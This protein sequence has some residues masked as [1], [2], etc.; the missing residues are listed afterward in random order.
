MTKEQK[1]T[2]LVTA[3][4]IIMIVVA[5]L[6]DQTTAKPLY[7]WLTIVNVP[8]LF[9]VA[10]YWATGLRWREVLLKGIKHYVVP[11]AV[12]A[13]ITI[14]GSK[15]IIKFNWTYWMQYRFVA[16]RDGV[17]TFLY[18]NGWPTAHV[19]DWQ[20]LGTGM[21]WIALALFVATIVFKVVQYLPG[22][23]A[24]QWVVTI[25]LAWLGYYLSSQFQMPWSIE[26]ALVM[27]PLMMLGK[28]L[29]VAGDWQVGHATA[30]AGFL[31][32]TG[33]STSGPF[34]VI[35][36]AAPHWVFT[37][38]GAVLGSL[39]IVYLAQRL[40]QWTPAFATGFAKLGDAVILK[41]SILTILMSL[42]KM[43][44]YI[45]LITTDHT[46]NVLLNIV[47]TLIVMGLL[48]WGARRIDWAWQ[49]YFED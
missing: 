27:Q 28:Q 46:I 7:Q 19:G 12:T 31:V 43:G 49:I 26:G 40:I 16:M 4:A 29:R 8:V 39:T 42:F 13:A 14:L 18:G 24:Y 2:R 48:T 11:F 15:V 32:W 22:H 45:S 33:V 35:M 36:A 3:F 30:A 34:D 17:T 41:I 20:V 37:S 9:M 38:L 44:G 47:V 25:L 21:I 6:I 23:V 5:Q 1:L 10:G